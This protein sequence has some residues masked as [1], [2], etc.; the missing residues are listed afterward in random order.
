MR[1]HVSDK[2]DVH[3]YGNSLISAFRN[4]AW[5]SARC[6]VACGPPLFKTRGSPN[7]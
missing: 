1:L 4:I 5:C 7:W 2:M 6:R 3:T